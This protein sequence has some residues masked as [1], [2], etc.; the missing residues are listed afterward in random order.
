MEQ[1][2]RYTGTNYGKEGLVFSGTYDMAKKLPVDSRETVETVAGLYTLIDQ[3]LA[4]EGLVVFC[5]ETN[6]YY[7][8]TVDAQGTEIWENLAG[9][10]FDQ[11]TEYDAD[12]ETFKFCGWHPTRS[13]IVENI[14]K[15]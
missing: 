5:K 4:Y 3:S 1:S 13:G 14:K 10:F 9:V 7:R 12:T 2:D 11:N 6:A 15:S 8:C